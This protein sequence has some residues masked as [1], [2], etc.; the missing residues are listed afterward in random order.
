MPYMWL[1]VGRYARIP[2]R[3]TWL[4]ALCGGAND[5]VPIGTAR[6]GDTYMYEIT[7]SVEGMACGMCESHVNDAVRRAFPQVRK[8]TSSHRKGT[9]TILSEEDLDQTAL[10]SAIDATGYEATAVAS[11]PHGRRGLF[12]GRER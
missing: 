3:R 11:R 7:V 1:R 5:S 6:E 9:T 4:S 2:F 12:G 8:V 10:L